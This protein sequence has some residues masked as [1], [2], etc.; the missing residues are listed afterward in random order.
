[1]DKPA[2]RYSI[3]VL[4][5]AQSPG[6][7]EY[8]QSLT[9][10]FTARREPFEIIIVANES[11]A[12][13]RQEMA[14]L[15]ST[16]VTAIS[17]S[18]KAPQ[19]VCL[20]A[21]FHKS[22][23]EIIVACGAYQQ[24]A[25]NSFATLLDALDEQTDLVSPWRQQR[26]DPKINQLQ[27]RLF[28]AIVKKVVGTSCHDLSCAVKVFR[29]RVLEETRLYG[30]M[31]RFLPIVAA[32]RGFHYKEI[33]CEHLEERGKTGLYGCSL[34]FE[35]I[36][37]ILTLYFNTRFARKPLRFF[38]N[39]GAFFFGTGT[40]LALYVL[41]EKIFYDHPLGLR[42]GFLLAI[43]FMVLG[44]QSASV[45]LLGEIIAFAQGRQQKEYSIEKII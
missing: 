13:L 15:H 14:K 22:H 12:F 11:E 36:I 44:A 2:I 31:Y 16:C 40:L 39:I 4:L 21:G 26:V 42:P 30:N 8:I 9:T 17:L 24:I 7:A 37:D 29:R 38:S 5:E 32:R 6:L 27:S 1:M 18:R 23:G 25:G 35:R 3:I 28:N 34:Y 19:A 43:F 45:G 33:P 41:A 10:I 20:R